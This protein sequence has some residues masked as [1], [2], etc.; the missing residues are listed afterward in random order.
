MSG[1]TLE[2]AHRKHVDAIQR[3]AADSAIGALSNV[4]TPYPADGAEQWLAWAEGERDAGTG[5]HFAVILDE[6]CIGSCGL[7]RID[8]KARRC[9]FGYWV[10]KPF[11]GRGYATEA[12]RQALRY[13]FDT[14]PVDAVE[15][16]CLLRNSASLRVLDKL[17]FKRFSETSNGDNPKWPADEPIGH[18]RLTRAVWQAHNTQAAR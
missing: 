17:G 10:A 3:Y 13:G 5:I 2:F 16:C 7:T 14:L 15:A 12:G 4:P 8:G 9:Q 11:W 18:Y 6:H 1:I